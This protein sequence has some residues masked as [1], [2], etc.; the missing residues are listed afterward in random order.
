MHAKRVN[1]IRSRSKFGSLPAG[2][3][4]EPNRAPPISARQYEMPCD[5]GRLAR[6]VC[7]EPSALQWGNGTSRIR[8]LSW[9]T[10]TARFRRGSI[11]IELGPTIVEAAGCS[12]PSPRTS[13]TLGLGQPPAVDASSRALLGPRL[14]WEF[15]GA[16]NPARCAG[17]RM[18]YPASA[19]EQHESLEPRGLSPGCIGRCPGGKR[20]TRNLSFG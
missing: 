13:R 5:R 3:I 20:K 7:C 15:S 10:T 2:T 9:S 1:R 17:R 14:V 6:T 8:L 19:W 4:T 11:A 16:C 12:P 18:A